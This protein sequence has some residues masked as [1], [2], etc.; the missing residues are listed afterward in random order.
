MDENRFDLHTHSIVSDGT[1]QPREVVE[2]ALREKVRLL[3]LTD[4]DSILGVAEAVE[5]GK[6]L[7]VPVLFTRTVRI[8][9][10]S[11]NT[12]NSTFMPMHWPRISQRPVTESV[13]YSYAWVPTIRATSMSMRFPCS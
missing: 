6:A 9:C 3:A 4:H 2:H 1:A 7:G 12:C 5:A 10:D 11:T 8:T 13:A